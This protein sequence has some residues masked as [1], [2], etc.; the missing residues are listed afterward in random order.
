M[1]TGFCQRFF[2]AYIDS[3]VTFLL[4][5]VDVMDYI[6]SFLNAEPDRLE[7][8]GEKNPTLVMVYNSFYT[9]LD[10]AC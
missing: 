10:S 6:N 5:L 7:Y 1:G 9:L 2:S 3:P 4:K 8:L